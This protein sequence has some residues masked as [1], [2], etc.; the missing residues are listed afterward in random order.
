MAAY[1][2]GSRNLSNSPNIGPIAMMHRGMAN[3]IAM[4]RSLYCTLRDFRPSSA[5]FSRSS[6]TTE[7]PAAVTAFAMAASVSGVPS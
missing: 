4:I 5:A 7:Y 6:L 2:N 3:T 1:G